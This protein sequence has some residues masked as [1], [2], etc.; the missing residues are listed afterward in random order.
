M[1]INYKYGK[2]DPMNLAEIRIF[3]ITLTHFLQSSR[4][5]PLK[6]T[7][8]RKVSGVSWGYKMGNWPKLG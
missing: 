2:L 6:N 1:E 7:R 8:E 3:H 4:F 5:K